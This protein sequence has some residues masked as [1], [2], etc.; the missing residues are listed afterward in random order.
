LSSAASSNQLAVDTTHPAS[1]ETAMSGI[2]TDLLAVPLW[3]L[4]FPPLLLGFRMMNGQ[5]V[6]GLIVTVV[7]VAVLAAWGSMLNHYADWEADQ[8]NRKRTWLHRSLN[9]MQLLHYQWLPLLVLLAI[10]WLGLK[11]N[12]KLQVL[13]SLGLVGAAQY[14]LV[15]KVKDRLWLNYL[16]LALA[17][18][19]WPL[20]VGIFVAGAEIRGIHTPMLLFIAFFLLLL[21]LGIAPSKD[22]E[23]RQGDDQT[24]KHTLP[25]KY[26]ESRTIRF[27]FIMVFLAL[28]CVIYLAAKMHEPAFWVTTGS[29][30]LV[31]LLLQ[32]KRYKIVP[33]ESFVCSMAGMSIVIRMSL[34]IAFV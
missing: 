25:N 3:L 9:R 17:Y 29:C 5:D 1:V 4:V 20:L 14:S 13:L 19:T 18:G 7:A 27:Q 11:H 8:I 33:N 12:W 26:G 16:Y 32:L 22:Y 2:L 10:T 23:D 28:F 6:S 34:V 31:L 21:D 15:A 24:G 30:V